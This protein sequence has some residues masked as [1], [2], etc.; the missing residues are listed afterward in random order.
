M[1]EKEKMLRGEAYH[2]FDK[3]LVSQRIETRLLLQQLNGCQ[4]DKGKELKSQQLLS[5]L[6]Y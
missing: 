1:T 2:P 3:E 6:Y 4:P 5:L